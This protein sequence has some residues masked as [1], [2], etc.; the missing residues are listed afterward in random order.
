MLCAL[1]VVGAGLCAGLVLWPRLKMK[2]APTSLLYF[3][4]IA[5]SQTTGD[6]YATSLVELTQDV[7]ALVVEI[8]AALIADIAVSS[9]CRANPSRDPHRCP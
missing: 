7:E 4:H 1:A 3:H 8:A 6:T 9:Q 2:E 5:C